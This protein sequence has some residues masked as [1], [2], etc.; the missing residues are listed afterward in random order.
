[1]T[2][3]LHI[4]YIE[5]HPASRKVM[6]LI[7]TDIM[8]FETVTMLDTTEN[9]SQQIEQL[10]PPISLV[11]TDLNINPIDGYSVCRILRSHE[12]YRTIPIVGVTASLSPTEMRRMKDVGFSGVITKPLNHSTFPMT[13]Q[14]LLSG[15]VVWED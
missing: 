5:D 10:V 8:G 9:L 12:A 3:T 14:R 2:A 11:F 13:V 15:E 1:M 7:L 4:L 6:E